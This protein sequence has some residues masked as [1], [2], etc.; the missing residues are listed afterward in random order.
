MWNPSMP[1]G[2]AFASETPELLFPDMTLRAAAVVPPTVTLAVLYDA[3][4]P[5]PLGSAAAPVA[6]VP[7]KLP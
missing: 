6:S 5:S 2:N 3:W 1:A 4:T 7:M